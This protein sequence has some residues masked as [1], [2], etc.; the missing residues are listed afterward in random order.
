LIKPKAL[1]ASC[2]WIVTSVA[3]AT[4]YRLP[5]QAAI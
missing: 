5:E 4:K 2:R 1:V 3:E